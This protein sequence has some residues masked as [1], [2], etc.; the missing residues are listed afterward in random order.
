MPT[1]L[2]NKHDRTMADS[3][4]SAP[5]TD[6]LPGETP[7]QTK[8]RLRRERLAAKSGASRLQK[9]TALQGGPSKSL[10]ELEKDVPGK[11]A[12]ISMSDSRLTASQS[13]PPRLQRLVQ[14]HQI[15]R[16]STY[17]ST[18]S[19]PPPS[20]VCPHPLLSRAPSR[21]SSRQGHRHR[22]ANKTP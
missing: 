10:S 8:A 18:T 11:R 5:S 3:P 13:S 6:A 7:T 1:Y 16:R 2:H 21:A 14:Q 4:A 19:N 9:I 22:T 15:R 17:R 20:P 12:L